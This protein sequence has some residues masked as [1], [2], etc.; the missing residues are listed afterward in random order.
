MSCG[1]GVTVNV[2][3]YLW[4]VIVGAALIVIWGYAAGPRPNVSSGAPCGGWVRCG[5]AHECSE[6][7]EGY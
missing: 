2:I 4:A 1:C 5:L 6:G 3:V 7:Y